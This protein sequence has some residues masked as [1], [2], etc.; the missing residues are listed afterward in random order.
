MKALEKASKDTWN[1]GFVMSVLVSF[2]K[3]KINYKK[4]IYLLKPP[5]LQVVKKINN[6]I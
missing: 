5:N 1:I 6:Q 2:Q 3:E 4:Y